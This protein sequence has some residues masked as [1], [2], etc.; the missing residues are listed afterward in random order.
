MTSL[1]FYM[2]PE[3]GLEPARIAP[4]PPQGG[5]STNFTTPAGLLHPQKASCLLLVTLRRHMSACTY[6]LMVFDRPT[7]CGG[8]RSFLSSYPHME[9]RL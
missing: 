5:V 6:G 7:P 3:T 2:V 1:P 4:P 8:R 9:V